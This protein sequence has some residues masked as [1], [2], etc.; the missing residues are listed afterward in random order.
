MFENPFV[1]NGE[2]LI[3]EI[4]TIHSNPANPRLN[5]VIGLCPEV[6]HNDNANGK[7]Q[8]QGNVVQVPV[9]IFFAFVAAH[10]VA[11]V[12]YKAKYTRCGTGHGSAYQQV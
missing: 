7:Q 8:A 1:V 5:A 6:K 3:K 12:L 2:L 10:T 4:R 9:K 11:G